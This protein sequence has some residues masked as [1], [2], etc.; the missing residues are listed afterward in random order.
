MAAG[1]VRWSSATVAFG[2]VPLSEDAA[3]G[4][5]D[6]VSPELREDDDPL[7]L[8]CECRVAVPPE[9]APWPLALV[10]VLERFSF[11]DLSS[12]GGDVSVLVDD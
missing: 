5:V 7:N 6:E 8:C 12:T 11:G 10:D 2:S 4:D 9:V 1:C 3:A